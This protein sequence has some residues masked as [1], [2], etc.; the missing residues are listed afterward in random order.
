MG[1]STI[2]QLREN[3][4]IETGKLSPGQAQLL[5]RE[6]G[7][8]LVVNP[9][10]EPGLYQITAKQYIGTI[11]LDDLRVLIQPK[12]PIENLFYMLTYAYKLARFRDQESLLAGSDDLF[13]FIVLIFVKQVEQLVR[14]GI[15]RS[16]IDYED[17]QRFLRGRLI[18]SQHLQRNVVQAHRF[19]Q[20]TNEFTPDVIE[21][22]ILKY[23]L[24]QLSRLNYDDA[25]LR[26]R[27]RRSLSAFSEVSLSD[28][29]VADCDR[30][31]YNRLNLSYETQIQL[32][33][34]LLQHL[35]VEGHAGQN[36]FA[37]YLLPMYQ[38][39]E[40]FVANYLAAYFSEHNSFALDI[41]PE[42]W[43]DMDQ[44]ERGEPD[45]VLTR[46]GRPYMVLDTKYKIFSGA[47]SQS[48]RN[49]MFMYCHTLGLSQGTLIYAG[50]QNDDYQRHFKGVTVEA[51]SL[52]LA[53]NL[54]VFQ[55]RCQE[56]AERFTE[57]LAG[58]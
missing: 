23:A 38:V 39:F 25:N 34:L 40:V 36:T 43:L 9:S 35:S 24:W 14:H 1:D 41:K 8:Y 5:N 45:L 56:F 32:A 53:D 7:R 30:V 17:N 16:Y 6:Y 50:K 4:M 10:W 42:I 29:S 58:L 15:Y 44:K 13:E 37:T 28:I 54:S 33:K 46:D 51:M 22:Q 55:S 3:E 18:L 31:I 2:L 26:I 19:F 27:L 48:D 21:N 12:V 11:V 49:Q 47:P 20:R 52:S 57:S